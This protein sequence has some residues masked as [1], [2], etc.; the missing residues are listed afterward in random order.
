MTQEEVKEKLLDSEM[1]N[2]I[3]DGVPLRFSKTK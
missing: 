2:I 1:N 3:Y